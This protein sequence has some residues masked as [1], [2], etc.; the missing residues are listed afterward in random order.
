MNT[1][2]EKISVLPEVASDANDE[3]YA[4]FVEGRLGESNKQD[5]LSIVTG[6]LNAVPTSDHEALFGDFAAAVHSKNMR[7]LLQTITD[8]ASTGEAYVTPGMV[9]EVVAARDAY[10]EENGWDIGR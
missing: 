6:W 1:P 9:D 2:R 4:H 3:K 8:W 10:A 5:A 7:E